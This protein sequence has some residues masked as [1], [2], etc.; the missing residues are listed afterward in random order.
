MGAER[1]LGGGAELFTLLTTLAA[2]AMIS[3]Y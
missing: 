2:H 3:G 1:F